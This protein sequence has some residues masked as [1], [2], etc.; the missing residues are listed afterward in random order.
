MHPTAG[1]MGLNVERAALLMLIAALVAIVT[2]RLRLPYSVGLVATGLVLTLLP[3]A[4]Q[5]A[6]TKDLLFTVLLPPLIFEAALSLDWDQLRRDFVLVLVLATL[7][8][9]LSATVTTIGNALL[10][11]LAL[12]CRAA[13][14][15]TYLCHRP[16]VCNSNL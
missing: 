2:R 13:F 4:P 6:L 12:G 10:C 16:G 7:G 3:F 1:L 14:R 5:V 15:I 8:V 11:A 9:V